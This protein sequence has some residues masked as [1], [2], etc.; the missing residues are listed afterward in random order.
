V[1]TETLL[2]LSIYSLRLHAP[3]FLGPHNTLPCILIATWQLIRDFYTI[4]EKTWPVIRLVADIGF[5]NALY[6]NE[7]A[8]VHRI[9]LFHYLFILKS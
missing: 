5:F 8:R 9:K 1:K 3:Y 7:D 2:F 6:L 4:T